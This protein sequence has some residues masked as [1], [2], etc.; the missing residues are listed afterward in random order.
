MAQSASP[1]KS[2]KTPELRDTSIRTYRARRD[3]ERTAEPAPSEKKSGERLIFVVQKHDATRLHWDF[4]L[5]HGG[6]LLSWA[7]PRGPSLDPHDKRLAVHVED[8]PVE[9]ARFEGTIPAGEYGAGTVEIWDRG[10]WEPVG[11]PEAAMQKGDF[12]FVLH[13]ERLN[14]RFVLVRMKPRPKERAENW[15]LIKEHDEFEREGVGAGELEAERPQLAAPQKPKAT[16]AAKN[17]Q[18]AAAPKKPRA[19][20]AK[21]APQPDAHSPIRL[22]HEDRELW[23][24]ITKRDLATYW[25]TVAEAALPGIAHRPLALVRCPEGIAGEHFFQKHRSKGMPP[26]IREGNGGQA[27]VAIDDVDGLVACVQF[28]SIELHTWGCTEDDPDH[29]DRLVFDLDPGEGVTMAEIA[30]AARE[31]RDRLAKLGLESFCRTSGGKGLHV[32]APLNPRPSWD[33]LR[34]WCHAFAR[35]MEA[36][37]P[38][39]FVSTVPKERRRGHILVDWLRNGLGSTATVSFGPRARP[40]ATVATPLAWREVT[41]KLD[42]AAF[43][44]RTIPQRLKRQKRDPW[45]GFD[46]IA[47]TLPKEG[48]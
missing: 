19:A 43:T 13:G 28:S 11:D 4:R 1:P 18:A 3:F 47:Q 9:Y 2:R 32:V 8:H 7:V 41:A 5:E 15:L 36:D 6:V 24:G 44:I 21:P 25:E 30:A 39:R 12:K 16:A 42:P 27:Y 17:E 31:V 14:G 23:P 29:A 45:E 10:T 35:L 33:V 37:A 46:T 38:D 48:V 34:P 26:Q 40:G 20:S 22:T